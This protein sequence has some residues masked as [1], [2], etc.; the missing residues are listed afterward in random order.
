MNTL[1]ASMVLTTSLVLTA[2]SINATAASLV[3]NL[4]QPA[5]ATTNIPMDAGWAAQSFTTDAA[6]YTLLSVDILAGDQLNMPTIVAELHAGDVNT[7]G[8]K[9]A[10]FSVSNVPSPGIGVV[11][12]TPD[13]AVNLEPGT[14]YWIVMGVLGS[15]SFGWSYAD[16][17]ITVGSGYLG[18]YNYSSDSGMTWVNYG[19]LNPYHMR[20]N[21]NAIPPVCP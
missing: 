7:V 1:T 21:V 14:P 9:L 13:V 8:A 17:E 20:V 3:S 18:N 10:T 4:D 2:V 5:R 19:Q 6:R 15:G 11:T 12:L 16:G